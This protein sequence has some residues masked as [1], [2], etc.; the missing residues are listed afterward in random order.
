MAERHE[1]DPIQRAWIYGGPGTKDFSSK[2][3]G[4]G[5]WAVDAANGDVGT[6]LKLQPR[7]DNADY[8]QNLGPNEL[9]RRLTRV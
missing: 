6:S 9:M 3:S 7:R 8:L 1:Y 4:F 2:A 5:A